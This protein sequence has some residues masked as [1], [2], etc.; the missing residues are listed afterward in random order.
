VV[1]I[2]IA[3]ASTAGAVDDFRSNASITEKKEL[4][5]KNDTLYLEMNKEDFKNYTTKVGINNMRILILD[6]KETLA[7][8]PRFTV[9]KSDDGTIKLLFNKSS[10]GNNNHSAKE[11][12]SEIDYNYKIEGNKLLLDPYF[13]I[14]KS[15]KWRSQ[16][17]EIT[18]KIPDGKIIYL[19]DNLLPII[20]NVC[21]TSDTWDGDM[22]DNFWIMKPE[23]LSLLK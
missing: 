1:G 2:I 21:N 14:N 7:G 17:L 19:D 4:G 10:K 23:G 5:I 11:Y 6:H 3:I 18:L 13:T 15:G 12:A 16:E 8:S 22:V 9:K 20:H